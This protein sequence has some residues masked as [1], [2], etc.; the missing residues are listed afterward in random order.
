[1]T[2]MWLGW[3]AACSS[4]GI[5]CSRFW[6]MTESSL[7]TMQP[8]AGF[9]PRFNGERSAS[10]INPTMANSSPPGSLPSPGLVSSRERA[11]STISS[12][13][14]TQLDVDSFIRLWPTPPAEPLRH[15]KLP[16]FLHPLH[17]RDERDLG[18]CSLPQDRNDILPI[19]L[20][21]DLACAG[22][23]VFDR[24]IRHA[25]AHAHR[26]N[27]CRDRMDRRGILLQVDF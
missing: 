21:R 26:R 27:R 11:R 12:R 3:L 8:N 24:Q 7:P 23:R 2:L 25:Q 9:A 16:V 4:T 15:I 19:H 18:G 1:R 10:G 17:T 13:R 5:A 6:S 22:R 14:A 20:V